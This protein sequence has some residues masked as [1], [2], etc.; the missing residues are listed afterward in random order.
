MHY[1]VRRKS[2]YV[3][4][5]QFKARLFCRLTKPSSRLFLKGGDVI[6][7]APQISGEHE[8]VLSGFITQCAQTGYGD[9]LIDIGANIGLISCQA[10]SHFDMVHMFE[11][12]PLCV[13][14]LSVNAE[15]SLRQGH[16]QIHPVGI[17]MLQSEL[18]LTV[19][20]NNWGGAFVKTD[21][22]AYSDEVLAQKDG[23]SS[24]D[25]AN[26]F[27]VTVTIADGI[28]T[29]TKIFEGLSANGKTAG[30]IKIDVEG[31]ETPILNAIARTLPD[32]GKLVIV[33]E[34]WDV[35]F[36]PKSL[37]A[38]FEGRAE[39]QV[40]ERLRPWPEGASYLRKALGLIFGR[41]LCTQL[42]PW[43][44]AASLMGDLVLNVVPRSA[45]GENE[46]II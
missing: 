25:A 35:D 5:E 19:P 8:P 20:K 22:N 44:Q 40:F 15:I 45:F 36:D 2:R 27:E 42:V 14:I 46:T 31:L 33:F 1:S 29:L 21:D 9:Y 6:S 43:E 12:N 38:A 16:F 37:L 4:L 39:L 3:I 10:G 17:G 23:F 32:S 26:Y 13:Q 18:T 41:R 11:P 30:V 28:T 24:L 7:I 34:N